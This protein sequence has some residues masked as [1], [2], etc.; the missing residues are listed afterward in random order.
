MRELG[1]WIE[2]F[3]KYTEDSEPPASF[4]RWV[5][6]G[7]I[8]AVL[9][10][11]VFLQWDR[12]L[13]PN[14]YIVLVGPAGG[15]MKNTAMFPGKEL[16]QETGIAIA[17]DSTT[18]EALIR[19]IKDSQQQN[20]D[21]T[22]ITF[23]SSLTVF[24]NEFTVF[25]GYKNQQ[26]QTDLCDWW[27]CPDPWIYDTKDK[28]L[29]DQIQ[30]LWVNIIAGTTPSAIK[31]S[32]SD[33][34]IGGGLTSRIIFIY[35]EKK[36]KVVYIPPGVKQTLWTKKLESK[37][38]EIETLKAKLSNDLMRIMELRGEFLTTECFIDEWIRFKDFYE[39][40]PKFQNTP[41][42]TFNS[43]RP[44][45][46]LKL[47]MILS[48]SCRDDLVIDGELLR[49]SIEMLERAEE[50]MPLVFAG[51]GD[52]LLASVLPRI[53]KLIS[54]Q[55]FALRSQLTEQ[56]LYELLPGELDTAM[57]VLCGTGRYVLKV[58]KE[59]Q[60]IYPNKKKGIENEEA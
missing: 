7:T 50:K 26:L 35:E 32:L 58:S 30:K 37:Q 47:A 20:V 39:N 11:K 42:A 48:A 31:A 33:E 53:E 17:A 13:F 54:E 59:G 51:V 28:K 38:Q 49:Q 22:N 43:R 27:D 4:R 52:S 12:V 36:E 6:V 60:G 25:L 18:R 8:A 19:N 10:R 16:A 45:H 56:F 5:A 29:R 41:L 34:S 55:G 44:T 14:K 1:D 46:V 15:P 40:N 2:N 3:L 23:H 24:S 57:E 21:G 9:Q